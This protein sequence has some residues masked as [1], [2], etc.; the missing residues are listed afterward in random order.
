MTKN[1]SNDQPLLDQKNQNNLSFTSWFFVY[2]KLFIFL[3]I[4]LFILDLLITFTFHSTQVSLNTSIP[5]SSTI[6][7]FIFTILVVTLINRYLLSPV[8]A[9]NNYFR[10]SLE[11][12]GL[13][14]NASNNRNYMHLLT[15]TNMMIERLKKEAETL[16]EVEV[17][18]QS[19]FDT[20][21][22]FIFKIDENGSL[23][24]CNKSFCELI[25]LDQKQSQKLM[26][27]DYPL[28]NIVSKVIKS[29]NK[30]IKIALEKKEG[31][32]FFSNIPINGHIREISWRVKCRKP[33]ISS[34]K[35]VT[36]LFVGRDITQQRLIEK[37][38][39][40]LEKIVTVSRSAT[41]IAHEI[42]QP[43][44][45][46]SLVTRNIADLAKDNTLD[47]KT[48]NEKTNKIL[49][50]L[51]RIDKIIRQLKVLYNDQTILKPF[52]LSSVIK[53]FLSDKK[54]SFQHKNIYIKHNLQNQKIWVHGSETLFK[55]VIHNIFKNS[56]YAINRNNPKEPTFI[57]TLTNTNKSA[58]L[59]L[60]DNGGG[61]SNA[62]IDKML[63]P[64]YSTKP[65]TDGTG[66]GLALC[67]DVI[68]KMNGNLE[69]MNIYEG[70][71]VSI[72]LPLIP[73]PNTTK[74][75]IN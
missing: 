21:S 16:K 10:Q 7:A 73:K 2:W 63:Q 43:L 74:Q 55:Q 58:N 57:I 17:N 39:Q 42:N 72:T 1:S 9:F 62:V 35:D 64:Y 6:K 37:K 48:L 34:H 45:V 29:Y 46:I 14:I 36:Y 25:G 33:S 50:Q 56:A 18:Y 51:N 53:D 44:S 49:N 5:I 12:N 47:K 70:F 65:L 59:Q 41:Y 13:I 26:D 28:E 60:C 8:I 30:V 68:A 15:D 3:F 40:E 23:F 54:D 32:E 69:C 11:E 66:I 24:Y 61:V 4:F 20:Q 71:L 31:H 67:N 52:E 75:D 19:I 27:G 38:N 22:D